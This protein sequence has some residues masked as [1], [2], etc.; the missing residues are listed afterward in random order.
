MA[1]KGSGVRVPLAPPPAQF[2]FRYSTCIGFTALSYREQLTRTIVVDGA[3]SA[4][5]GGWPLVHEP[6][7]RPPSLMQEP[8]RGIVVTGPRRGDRPVRCDLQTRRTRIAHGAYKLPD[9]IP[10]LA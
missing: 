2:G 4:T 1:C 8:P 3:A 5:T 9:H 7:C 6:P 10:F